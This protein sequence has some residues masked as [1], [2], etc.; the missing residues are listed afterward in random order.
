MSGRVPRAERAATSLANIG[1]NSS[2]GNS[3]GPNATIL[4]GSTTGATLSYTGGTVSTNRPITVIARTGA[5]TVAAAGG[6]V[7]GGSVNTTTGAVMN[8]V[9][10]QG[11]AI[12]YKSD[13]TNW[14]AV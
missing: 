1:S 9:V 8:G 2:L 5:Q 7:N 10:S 11:D 4:L 3:T 12:T 6:T 13:S 14:Y